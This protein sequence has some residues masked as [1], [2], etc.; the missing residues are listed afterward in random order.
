MKKENN[1]SNLNKKKSYQFFD[2]TKINKCSI[3]NV[4]ALSIL[5]I[6]K[7]WTPIRTH[8]KKSV[9]VCIKII[10][11]NTIKERTNKQEIY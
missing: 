8:T 11:T 7:G 2:S 3:Q 4:E 5:C 10:E 1:W 9:G 6:L